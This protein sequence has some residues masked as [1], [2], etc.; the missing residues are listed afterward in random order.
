MLIGTQGQG[1]GPGGLFGSGVDLA[2]SLFKGASGSSY[3]AADF[4]KSAASA[5]PGA[6]GP[7]FDGGGF[8]G[9]GGRYDIAGFVHRGEVVWSQDDV[10]RW[11]GPSAVD[12]MRRGARGYADGG[13]VGSDAFTMPRA[14]AIGTAASAA[15]TIN[16]IDQRPAGSPDI[17]PEVTRRPDG[18]IDVVVKA[19]ESKMTARAQSGRG[20]L[21]PHISSAAYRS[22]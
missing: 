12:A 16:F 10:K 20:G 14:G 7:G 3:G 11:G 13:I 9:A 5:A 22:G 17:Q 18:S 6:Y 21:A 19:L 1:A 15:P 8:T 4:F 2:K